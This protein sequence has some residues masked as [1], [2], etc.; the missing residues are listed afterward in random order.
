VGFSV[1]HK[2]SVQQAGTVWGLRA[3][4]RREGGRERD[5]GFE[6]QSTSAARVTLVTTQHR[7][8]GLAR[9]I[10]TVAFLE[11]SQPSDLGE[12]GQIKWRG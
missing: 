5:R 6:K 1:S 3:T 8:N 2:C 7:E 11:A 12:E 9:L 4:C 10:S